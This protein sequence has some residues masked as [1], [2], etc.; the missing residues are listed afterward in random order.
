MG[1]QNSLKAESRIFCL[2][3]GLLTAFDFTEVDATRAVIFCDFIYAA[4][5]ND[6]R[7]GVLLE[8]LFR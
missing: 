5:N 1:F 7:A 4:Y 6:Y 3:P 2:R 8:P